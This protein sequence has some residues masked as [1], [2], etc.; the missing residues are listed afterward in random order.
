VEQG[1]PPVSVIRH[2]RAID[3]LLWQILVYLIDA[4]GVITAGEPQDKPTGVEHG[5]HIHD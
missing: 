1:R 4:Q 5:K 2:E 3:E